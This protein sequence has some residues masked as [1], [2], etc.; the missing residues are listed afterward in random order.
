MSHISHSNINT[1]PPCQLL[2]LSNGHGEDIIAVRI[3]EQLQQ[4]PHPPKIVALPLVGEGKAYQQRHIPL[5]GSVKNMPSGGFL[6]MDG[7]QLMKDVKGGLLQLILSQIKAVRSWVSYHNQLGDKTAILAVG[8]I[9]PLLFATFSRTNYAFVGTAKSEYYVQDEF[10]ILPRK[11]RNTYWENFS[12]SIYHPWERWLMTR[13]R[14]RAV[15]PRESLT[16]EILKKF[17]VPAFDLGN[18]MMDGLEPSLTLPTADKPLIITLLPGSR[19]PEAYHN[20]EIILSAVAALININHSTKPRLHSLDKIIFLAAIA[21]GLDNSILSQSLK[22]H[23]WEPHSQLPLPLPDNQSLIFKQ[24][25]KH[26]NIYLVLTQRAYNECL[27]WGDLAIAMAGT[28]TEQFVGLGKPAIAIIGKGPQYNSAF[29]EAQSR[30]LGA[31]LLLVDNP[32][33]VPETIQS[34]WQNPDAFKTIATNGLQRMGTPG[35]AR[36][37]AHCLQEQLTN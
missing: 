26:Q 22:S 18:P 3:V 4:Q 23:D 21:P 11:S 37:I 27:H 28:A 12:G 35:A 24:K 14:C 10:G 13:P 1:T 20:W 36:R 25:Y 33:K 32:F 5:I 16:T 7:R 9:V 6:Y 34:L 15:F 29:A 19:S 17:S 2:V 31:S 8:D 30:L